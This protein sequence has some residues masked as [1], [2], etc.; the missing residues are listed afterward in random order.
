MP[1]T[2]MVGKLRR[3]LETAIPVPSVSVISS[4][5]FTLSRSEMPVVPSASSA[6]N[7][8]VAAIDPF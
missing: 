3:R 6:S 2:S 4:V 7:T 5:A 1:G 8:V